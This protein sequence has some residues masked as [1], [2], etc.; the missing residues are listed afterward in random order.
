MIDDGAEIDT[1]LLDDAALHLDDA[2]LEHHLILASD[3]QEV[4][5]LFRLANKLLRDLQHL[6]GLGE[7]RDSARQNDIV[8]QPLDL[9]LGPGQEAHQGLG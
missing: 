2:D 8:I 9:N 7:V 1:Q 5:D 4:D 6:P 3:G